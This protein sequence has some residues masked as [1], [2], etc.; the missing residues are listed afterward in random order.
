MKTLDRII[1]TWIALAL[2]LIALQPYTA[3]AERDIQNVNLA[4]VGGKRVAYGGPIAV[5]RK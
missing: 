3:T 2:S 4:E 5:G 1:L